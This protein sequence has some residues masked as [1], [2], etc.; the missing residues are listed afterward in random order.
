MKI[1]LPTNMKP[2]AKKPLLPL[3]PEEGMFELTKENSTVFLLKSRPTDNDS[4][5]Y[6]KA[7]RILRGDES[8]RQILEWRSTTNTVLHGLNV[9]TAEN[10]IPLLEAMLHGTALTLFQTELARLGQNVREIQIAAAAD[11]AAIDALNAQNVYEFVDFAQVQRA[12][13][14]VVRGLAPSKALQRA[15]RHL[16]RE[17][18]KPVDMKVRIY[19]HHLLR[20]NDEEL[21][22]LPPFNRNQNLSDDELVDVLLFGTPKSWQKEMDKQGFDPVLHTPMQVVTFMERIETSEDFDP[23][24]DSS[25]KKAEGKKKSGKNGSAKSGGGDGQKFCLLHGKGNHSSDDCMKLKA[26]AKRLKTSNEKGNSNGRK[27]DKAPNKT[28]TRKADEAKQA[29]K[30]DLAAYV[31][32]AVAKKVKKELAAADKKRKSDDSDDEF[33]LNA[34]ELEG[35]NY[36]DME[37]LKIDDD[38]TEDGEISV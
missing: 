32:Q 29:A 10:A 2:A 18:R 26:E 34:V 20:I 23:A 33:D 6:K 13:N 1:A 36:D 35:F 17:C 19:Y 8:L 21:P 9:T 38:D 4:P 31:K 28:W 3:V 16:R 12:L 5:T 30:K 37:N 15:K 11:Q 27:F 24:K 25:V 14:H 7:H 22:N